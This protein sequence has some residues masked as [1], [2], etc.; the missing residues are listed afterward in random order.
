MPI[1]GNLTTRYQYAININ[2]FLKGKKMKMPLDKVV[3]KIV[4]LGV[5]GLVLVIVMATTGLAGGAAIVAALAT[6]G[7]PLGGMMVGLA[8]LGL[9]V[10]ISNAIAEYGVNVVANRVIQGLLEKGM[11]K[12]EIIK[13]IDS[14]WF[15]SSSLKRKMKDMVNDY[16]VN[17]EDD[18]DDEAGATV[19]SA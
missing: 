2:N 18:G 16:Q 10:L 11:S 17:D 8:V 6:L 1:P 14:Y 3:E 9:L 15:L 12:E 4:A 13:K 19:P 5:P 7:G